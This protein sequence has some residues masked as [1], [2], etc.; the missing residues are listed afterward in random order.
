MFSKDTTRFA[1]KSYRDLIITNS[2]IIDVLLI[3]FEISAFKE[4]IA[5]I[6]FSRERKEAL[7]KLLG[8]RD[9][10]RNRSYNLS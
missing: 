3:T 1:N 10:R 5:T 6:I 8:L 7:I 9:F 4:L 2:A